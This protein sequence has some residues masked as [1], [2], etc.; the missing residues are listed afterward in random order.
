PIAEVEKGG[1][2]VARQYLAVLAEI[3]DVV[4]PGG[5]AVIRLLHYGAAARLLALAKIQRKGHLLLVRDVLAVEYQH[6]VFAP[7]SLHLAALLLRQ[8]LPQIETGKLTAKML[9]QLPDGQGHGVV[10]PMFTFSERLLPR[11]AM[12]TTRRPVS[13]AFRAMSPPSTGMTAP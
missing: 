11:R 12:S 7:R 5:E 1:P 6:G 9:L 10:L 3:G 4:Q 13:H 2:A 8:R